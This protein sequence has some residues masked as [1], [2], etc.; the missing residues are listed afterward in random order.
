[1]ANSSVSL[2]PRSPAGAYASTPNGGLVMGEIVISIVIGG[3]MLL[4][5]LILR[6][7]LGAEAKKNAK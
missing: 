2:W 1:M 5:G 6:L 4:S 7:C 3:C